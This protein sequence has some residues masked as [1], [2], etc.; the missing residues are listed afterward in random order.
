MTFTETTPGSADLLPDRN[1][2]GEVRWWGFL[3]GDAYAN[4]F[5]DLLYAVSR[6]AG[7]GGSNTEPA[8]RSATFTAT[9][10][11]LTAADG[12]SATLPYAELDTLKL[13]YT[14][15]LSDGGFQVGA[16]YTRLEYRPVA[17]RLQH[18]NLR[19]SQPQCRLLIGFLYDH[20]VSFREYVDGQRSYRLGTNISY[21]RIQEL[22]AKYGIEW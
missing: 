5:H 6:R 9:A 22:K 8:K 12:T 7:G 20:R 17:G 13:N 2:L 3:R 21:D 4:P 15:Y 14:G 16:Y 11:T 18:L 10:L 1:P 19:M